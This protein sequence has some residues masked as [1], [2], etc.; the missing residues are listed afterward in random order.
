MQSYA[1]VYFIICLA[2]ST[3]LASEGMSNA[4]YGNF[5]EINVGHF[6]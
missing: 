2:M 4:L 5:C 3:E 1:D 6:P